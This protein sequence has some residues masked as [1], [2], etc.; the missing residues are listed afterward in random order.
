VKASLHKRLTLLPPAFA[1]LA[2]SGAV[3]TGSLAPPPSRLWI[4]FQ[5]RATADFR[6]VNFLTG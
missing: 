4:A 1:L 6:S 2:R 3:V 5:M